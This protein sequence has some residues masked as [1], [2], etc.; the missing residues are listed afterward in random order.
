MCCE[1]GG[2]KGEVVARRHSR[3]TQ[4]GACEREKYALDVG[5]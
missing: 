1:G 4:K 5:P 3:E 2:G